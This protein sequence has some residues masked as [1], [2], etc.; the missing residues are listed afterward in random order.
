MT[1]ALVTP[2]CWTMPT[3]ACAFHRHIHRADICEGVA[4][5]F[6]QT[7]QGTIWPLCEPCS[8]RFKVMVRTCLAA[9]DI[10]PN[11][12]T[13]ARFD[14]P[15]DDPIILRAYLEQDPARLNRVLALAEQWYWSGLRPAIKN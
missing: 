3:I 15:L 13:D 14:I 5:K 9:G 4:V 11:H 8:E 6:F 7:A 1:Q 10:G 2:S 12:V